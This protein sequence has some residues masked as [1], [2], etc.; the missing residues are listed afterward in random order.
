M[1]PRASGQ[2]QRLGVTAIKNFDAVF[3]VL[4]K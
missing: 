4:M 3:K 2:P 1:W